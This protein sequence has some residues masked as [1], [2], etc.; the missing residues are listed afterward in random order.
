MSKTNEKL[1]KVLEIAEAKLPE[2]DYLEVADCLKTLNN[3]QPT[4]MLTRSKV[5]EDLDKLYNDMFM[6]G[7]WNDHKMK[8]CINYSK[9]GKQLF[10][11]SISK[12]VY[13]WKNRFNRSGIQKHRYYDC[14]KIERG[15][16]V[17]SPVDIIPQIGEVS[18]D[19]Y[20]EW[21]TRNDEDIKYHTTNYAM[22]DECCNDILA[23]QE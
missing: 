15:Y 6:E 18:F 12:W 20:F 9:K 3:I 11:Y 10:H 17:I 22:V 14:S 16:K 19:I 23:D 21:R 2:G 7:F 5:F 13:D 1:L 8:F 4:T